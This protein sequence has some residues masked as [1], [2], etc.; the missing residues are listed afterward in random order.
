MRRLLLVVLV[1]ALASSMVVP[2]VAF[3]TVVK[4]PDAPVLVSHPF[5]AYS[6]LKVGHRFAVW[7]Y[8]KTRRDRPLT[9]G[10]TLRIFAW[11]WTRITT[12]KPHRS[13][14][15]T[16]GL[17]TQ[18]TLAATSTRGWKT[19]YGATMNIGAKGLYRLRARLAWVDAIGISRTMWSPPR[20][21][22]IK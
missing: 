15:A 1:A 20:D 17:T 12:P 11:R 16:D 9:T 4:A 3:A 19:R 6:A 21:I 2:A 5:T 14:V 7:G 8:V 18:A 13:W 10:A 22:L